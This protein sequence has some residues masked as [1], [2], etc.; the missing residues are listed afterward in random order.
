MAIQPDSVQS[1]ADVT[2]FLATTLPPILTT[3]GLAD[4]VPLV[5]LGAALE[6]L[7]ADLV[8]QKQA[9]FNPPVEVAAI[10]TGA[11]ADLTVRFPP[12]L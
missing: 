11:E 9:A 10:E 1:A 7:V 4:L 2:E 6:K 8:T 5:G 3:F 12:K